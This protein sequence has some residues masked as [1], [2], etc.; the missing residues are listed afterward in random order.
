MLQ[1]LWSKP[2]GSAQS[3]CGGFLESH[4]SC[5]V[6]CNPLCLLPSLG[7]FREAQARELRHLALKTEQPNLKSRGKA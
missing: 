4:Q 2:G 7:H 5:S 3:E 6:D 1:K